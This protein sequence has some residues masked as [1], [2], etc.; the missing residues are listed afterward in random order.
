MSLF[1]KSSAAAA[2]VE[3]PKEGVGSEA[4]LTETARTGLSEAEKDFELTEHAQEKSKHQR[5]H[6]LESMHA[7]LKEKGEKVTE[8]PHER[9]AEIILEQMSASDHN[10]SIVAF[11]ILKNALGIPYIEREEKI[12]EFENQIK[13]LKDSTEKF[14]DSLRGLGF[15]WGER[16][17]R[18]K[19]LGK[20][21]KILEKIEDYLK[22]MRKLDY[23]KRE[24]LE[25]PKEGEVLDRKQRALLKQKMKLNKERVGLGKELE[26]KWKVP[27]EESAKKG[28]K[29]EGDAEVVDFAEAKKE[30]EEAAAKAEAVTLKPEEEK[31][32]EEVVGDEVAPE[33]KAA[34]G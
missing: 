34:N 17:Q 22:R 11:E 20:F 9:Y 8:A 26:K 13:G 2:A 28:G 3:K 16:R 25:A 5:L 31:K 29:V 21:A 14:D 33:E 32:H 18:S 19:R 27:K 30:K 6:L 24:G 12:A 1:G 15:K 23:G 7:T 4:P 10:Y